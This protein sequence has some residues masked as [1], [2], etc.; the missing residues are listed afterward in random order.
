MEQ[1]KQYIK[2]V[3]GTEL[4]VVLQ[5]KLDVSNASGLERDLLASLEDISKLVLDFSDL[6]YISSAGL[7]VLL[8][9]LK[10]MKEQEGTVIVRN[11]SSEVGEVFR[12]TGLD[13]IFTIE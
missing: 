7:R 10:Q 11:L 6:F 12:M 9:V 2:S 5:G 13:Q 8:Q 3:N 4:T 1:L